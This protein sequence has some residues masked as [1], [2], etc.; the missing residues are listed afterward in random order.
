MRHVAC[1]AWGNCRRAQ[2]YDKQI[3]RP[4]VRRQAPR[5]QDMTQFAVAGVAVII[6]KRRQIGEEKR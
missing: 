5:N 6:R 4:G 2:D 1:F 3:P